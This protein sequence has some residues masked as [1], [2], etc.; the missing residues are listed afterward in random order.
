VKLKYHA[1][2]SSP[3]DGTPPAA[4]P[5]AENLRGGSL[6]MTR[7]IGESH[8]SFAIRFICFANRKPTTTETFLLRQNSPPSY[9]H[10]K[11]GRACATSL[12]RTKS[13]QR[14]PYMPWLRP[15]FTSSFTSTR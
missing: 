11:R 10:K 9:R 1:P 8:E 15:L 3:F 7:N 14:I 5:Q 6:R 12:S 2:D 13:W 4:K